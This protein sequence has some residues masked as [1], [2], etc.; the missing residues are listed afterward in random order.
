M[1]SGLPTTLARQPR[2][3]LTLP[4]HPE[5]GP[6]RQPPLPRSLERNLP[7]LLLYTTS[8]HY[9]SLQGADLAVA[10]LATSGSCLTFANLTDS[11]QLV[12]LMTPRAASL[13]QEIP[14]YN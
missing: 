8:E 3:L 9:N 5:R 1:S 10:R 12:L 2:R 13:A 4:L 11:L 6:C 14:D 7:A